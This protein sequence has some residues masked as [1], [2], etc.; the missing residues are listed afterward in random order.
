M[1][2]RCSGRDA[3]TASYVITTNGGAAAQAGANLGSGWVNSLAWSG[4]KIYAGTN[5]GQVF[6]CNS[7]TDVQSTGLDTGGAATLSL[8]WNG[9]TLYAG[10]DS[11]HI[12]SYDGASW[13]DIIPTGFY[14]VHSLTAAE[15]TLF[16]GTENGRYSG[17]WAG[18]PGLRAVSGDGQYRKPGHLRRPRLWT[19]SSQGP[20]GAR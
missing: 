18:P 15:G 20:G 8:C 4:T 3:S 12:Y 2:A 10:T 1:T 11:G 19:A 9:N 16:A 17:T 7:P 6:Q 13:T 14:D 5:D